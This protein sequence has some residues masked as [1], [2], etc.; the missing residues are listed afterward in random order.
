M[1]GASALPAALVAVVTFV[2]SQRSSSRERAG[3]VAL[4]K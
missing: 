3:I 2:K 1:A 4:Y